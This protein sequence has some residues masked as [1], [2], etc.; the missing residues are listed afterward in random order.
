MKDFLQSLKFKI[1]VGILALLL[2]IMAY[3]ASTEGGKSFI[4]S[5]IGVIVSPFQEISTA[6]SNKVSSTL[7]MLANADEYYEENQKLKKKLDEL[8]ADMVDYEKI[9]DD[10][11][12]YKEILELKEDYPDYKFSSPCSIIG[13]D[14]NDLYKS[15][16]INKGS[17]DG[18]EINDPVI[19]GEGIVGIISDVQLTYSKVTT[20]LSPQYP[21]GVI[22]SKTKEPGYI[23]G[24]YDFAN[25]GF[26][27]MKIL[28]RDTKIV[29]EDII[30]TSG[31]S[32]LVPADRIV[33]IVEKVELD[34]TGLVSEAWVKPIVDFDNIKNVFVITEF[35]GQ[36]EGYV[37]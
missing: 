29:K 19:T 20:V 34:K 23:E 36:G 4:S 7:D 8:Y 13:W 6:I 30:V 2:G 37:E 21:M 18:V 3:A 1:L 24:N 14:A 35:E 26:V 25:D 28:N 10:N 22:S 12:H 5:A 33:G 15:F 9:K 32:G 11:E 31:H 17:R 27:R 16:T